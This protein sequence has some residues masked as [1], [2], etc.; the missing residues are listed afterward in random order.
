M[1]V[2]CEVPAHT[3]W[4]MWMPADLRIEITSS[5]KLWRG[6]VTFPWRHSPW[7]FAGLSQVFLSRFSGEETH[8][9]CDISWGCKVKGQNPTLYEN[10]NKTHPTRS[11]Q[12]HS[13]CIATSSL[14]SGHT[15]LRKILKV[16]GGWD[17]GELLI[18]QSVL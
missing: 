3:E 8:R 1:Q 18:L 5:Y 7:E 2:E 13:F 15:E 14:P 17:M 6:S 10:N 4:P 11:L 16:A 12:G 9:V